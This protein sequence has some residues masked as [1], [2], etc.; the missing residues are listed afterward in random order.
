MLV[1]TKK[2][3]LFL[4]IILFFV[5][6]FDTAN[7]RKLYYYRGI[8]IKR[9]EPKSILY[10]TPI[11]ERLGDFILLDLVVDPGEDE[12]NTVSANI[13]FP[14]NKLSLEMLSKNNTFCLFFV[15]EEID[16][17]IGWAKISCMKPYPGTDTVSN[18][19]SLVFRKKEAGEANLVIGDS[20]VLAN[21]GYGTNVLKEIKNQTVFIR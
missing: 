19:I 2:V 20:L 3:F 13:F 8:K 17:E 1:K 21:D 16:N 12:I 9:Q 10:L 6:P 14:A 4:L 5:L 7:A 11:R 15:E 18:V